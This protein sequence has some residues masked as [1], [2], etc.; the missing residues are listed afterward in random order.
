MKCV[1]KEKVLDMISSKFLTVGQIA[2]D[3]SLAF[4]TVKRC[5][6]GNPVTMMVAQKLCTY[7]ECEFKDIFSIAKE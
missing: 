1:I 3:N 7:F 5:L 4:N 2:K 6:D